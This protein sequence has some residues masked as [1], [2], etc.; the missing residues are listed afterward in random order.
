[1]VHRTI[2]V[3]LHFAPVAWGPP[4][5][6]ILHRIDQRYRMRMP[7]LIC[8]TGATFLTMGLQFRQKPANGTAFI[9]GGAAPL[10]MG[11]AGLVFGIAF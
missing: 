3:Y 9:L 7:L 1:M 5:R 10:V 11:I 4:L 8:A 6:R 2:V